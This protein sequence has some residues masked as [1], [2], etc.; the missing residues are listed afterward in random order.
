MQRPGDGLVSKLEHRTLNNAMLQLVSWMC[1]FTKCSSEPTL[2]SNNSEVVYEAEA[3]K[4]IE[5]FFR[6]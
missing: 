5:Y 6:Y 3:N 4:F 1:S 2:C